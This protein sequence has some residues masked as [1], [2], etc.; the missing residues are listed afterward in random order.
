[1]HVYAEKEDSFINVEVVYTYI[2]VFP[3]GFTIREM[4]LV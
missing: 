4:L 1:M 2:H 3:N